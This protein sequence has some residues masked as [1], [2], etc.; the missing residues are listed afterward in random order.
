MIGSFLSPTMTFPS[1]Y[2]HHYVN[3]FQSFHDFI[4]SFLLSSKSARDS[5]IIYNLAVLLISNLDDEVESL[6]P[7]ALSSSRGIIFVVIRGQRVLSLNH[8]GTQDCRGPLD[9]T[10][11]WPSNTIGINDSTS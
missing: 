4:F 7:I 1:R 8:A 5:I 2:N 3:F 9:Q 6:I 11:V 10:Y